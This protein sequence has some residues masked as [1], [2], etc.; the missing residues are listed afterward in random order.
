MTRRAQ[1]VP[2][3]FLNTGLIFLKQCDSAFYVGK[4]M[5]RKGRVEGGGEGDRSGFNS[6]SSP[7]EI[8]LI[9]WLEALGY[10][11]LFKPLVSKASE[12]CIY[13]CVHVCVHVCVCICVCVCAYVCACVVRVC[14]CLCVHVFLCVCMCVFVC[15]LVCVHVCVCVCAC[16][17]V[18]AECKITGLPFVNVCTHVHTCTHTGGTNHW[19]SVC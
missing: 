1:N 7:S 3:L 9:N 15:V 6:P 16:V 8:G 17:C 12:L 13:V 5:W 10:M 18:S 4:A 19:F 11:Q 14:V 2:K